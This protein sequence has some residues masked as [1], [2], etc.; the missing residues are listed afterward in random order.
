[1]PI[2]VKRFT[3]T[4][5]GETGRDQQQGKGGEVAEINAVRR[6][7]GDQ[8]YAFGKGF[9]DHEPDGHGDQQEGLESAAAALDR[10]R[11]HP[12]W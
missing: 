9:N 6:S 4:L 10:S 8:D 3:A 1:M 5:D 7:E 11:H 2:D 12:R